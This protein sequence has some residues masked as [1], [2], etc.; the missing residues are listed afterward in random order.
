MQRTGSQPSA[1]METARVPGSGDA[2]TL[3]RQVTDATD[4]S[5]LALPLAEVVR[6]GYRAVLPGGS[7][8]GF[9]ASRAGLPPS[10]TLYCWDWPLLF[11]VYADRALR[12]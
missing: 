12:L 11:P 4:P 1:S 10:P 7:G 6:T 9:E 5:Y 3:M 8:V 2:I